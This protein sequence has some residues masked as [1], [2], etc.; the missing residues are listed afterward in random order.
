MILADAT[1]GNGTAFSLALLMVVAAGGLALG[2]VKLRGVGLGSAGVLF[3]GL[4]VGS[5]GFKLEASVM[6]FLREFGLML[7]VFTMG[8]QLG[9]GFFASLRRRA[10]S[11]MCWRW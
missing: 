3:F 11:S 10:S 4:I 9:P 8:L 1:H 7:F 6:E 5:F 2:N